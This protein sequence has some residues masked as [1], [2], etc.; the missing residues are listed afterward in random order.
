MRCISVVMLRPSVAFDSK[1]ALLLAHH[2]G[3]LACLEGGKEDYTSLA[4]SK[5]D[6]MEY[7]LRGGNLNQC[8]DICLKQA[9]I[10]LLD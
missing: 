6:H 4:D 10:C 9:I 2:V 7:C 5:A 1:L 8:G 3:A